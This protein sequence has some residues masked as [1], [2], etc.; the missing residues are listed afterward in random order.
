MT[1]ITDS[2]HGPIRPEVLPYCVMLSS[3]VP[4]LM[5][6]A[7]TKRL[8]VG[9]LMEAASVDGYNLKRIVIIM[10]LKMNRQI[11]RRKKMQPMA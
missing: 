9:C 1:T 5:T 8:S 11:F 4:R 3:I 6:A 7:G 10:M 2:S